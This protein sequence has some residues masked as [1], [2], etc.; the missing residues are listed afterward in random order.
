[1]ARMPLDFPSWYATL[2]AGQN[3]DATARW[4]GVAKAIADP[5]VDEV[6]A[7]VRLA[8][9]SRQPADA[10]VR[11]R[12]TDNIRAGDP[13]FGSEAVDRE[14]QILAASALVARLVPSGIAAIAITTAA[15]DGARRPDL[16]MDLP[17]LAETAVREKAKSSRA[18][19][20][21]TPLVATEIDWVL[22]EE[23]EA[24]A[25]P[26]EQLDALHSAAEEALTASVKN[27]NDVILQLIQRQE[28]IDE[29]LQMLWWLMAGETS[30]GVAFGEVKADQRPFVIAEELAR[31]TARL[32]GPMAIPALLSRSGL[33]RKTKI[34]IVDA[35]NAMEDHWCAEMAGRPTISPVTNPLHEA[36]RRRVETGRGPDWSKNWAAVCGI[37][38]GYALPALRLAELFYR[39][40]LL[41]TGVA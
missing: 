35:V 27:A 11:T 37:D 3:G 24:N 20:P 32:P 22:A 41:L 26:L 5:K 4:A 39:E 28:L 29:E 19:V 40:R 10:T 12:I 2:E 16:P 33:S 9:K 17:T 34:K 1:M 30:S 18:R 13:T 15:L 7:F 31:R 6:E 25:T 23:G 38:E 8:F 14:L 36:I 21:I